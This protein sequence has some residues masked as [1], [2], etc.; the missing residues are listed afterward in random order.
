MKSY[1][2]VYIKQNKLY[3]IKLNFY[4]IIKTFILKQMKKFLTILLS[5]LFFQSQAFCQLGFVSFIPNIAIGNVGGKAT[6]IGSVIAN[7][8][9]ILNDDGSLSLGEDKGNL[10]FKANS[11]EYKD[12]QDKNYSESKG[13]GINTSIGGN[14]T[15]KGSLNLAPQGN[16]TI[17]LK[18][19]GSKS[20]QTVKAT[21]GQG[22]ITIGGVSASEEQL[23]G[24]NRDITNT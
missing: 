1:I 4:I 7:A 13:F 16:T 2:K 8:D 5:I 19:T 18:N 24:L 9:L 15:D 10:N 12:L 21:M 14:I 11:F 23:A 20:E 22:N 3:H 6:N 17:S